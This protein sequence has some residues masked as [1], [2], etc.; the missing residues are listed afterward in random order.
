MENS[1]TQNV[2]ALCEDPIALRGDSGEHIIPNSIGGRRRIWG[3][4]CKDCNSRAGDSWDAELWRQFSHIASM[5]GIDRERGEIPA[6]P[7]KTVS[8]KQLVLLP[9]GSLMPQRISFAKVSNPEGK[10]FLINATVRTSHEAEDMVRGLA[11]RYPEINAEEM[12]SSLKASSEFIDSPITFG[13]GF[14]GPL[15]GRSM[16][17]TAIAMASHIGVESSACDLAL[18]YLL[19]E[20]SEAPYA[21]FYERDLVGKRPTTYTPHIVSVRG[22]PLSGYLW[23]YVEYF[24]MARIVV[25]LSDRYDGSPMS[26]TYAFNPANGKE[27]D[28]GVDL[29]FS[30]DEIERIKANKAYTDE[31]Y[32]AV[33]NSSFGIVY[34]RSVRRQVKKTFAESAAYAASKLGIN[35]GEVIAPEHAMKFAQYLTEKLQPLIIHMMKSGIPVAEAM[36]IDDGD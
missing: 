7:V 3:F 19:D 13:V 27:I 25:P 30:D 10:G 18:P 14:G 34:F 4:I 26:S 32:A 35:H 22:D 31:Q 36:R 21:L 1:N 15:G 11:A 16:V 2:C 6:I 33:A 20:N 9:D 28:I 5:H 17:K 23:G 29:S 24:G 8:G 12:L